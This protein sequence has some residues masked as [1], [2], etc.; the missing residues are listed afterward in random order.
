MTVTVASH[1]QV[2]EYCD[3][4]NNTNTGDIYSPF[5]VN[6]ARYFLT[7][8]REFD[9]ASYE[10]PQTYMCSSLCNCD[11][12]AVN[13]TL[14]PKGFGRDEALVYIGGANGRYKVFE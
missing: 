3:N 2:Q 11:A 8:V 5:T 10:L 14:Y 7:Y 6:L 13:R 1:M 12:D 9:E 4:H